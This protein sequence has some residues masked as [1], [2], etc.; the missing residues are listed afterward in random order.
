ME[1]DHHVNIHNSTNKEYNQLQDQPRNQYQEDTKTLMEPEPNTIQNH[2][3]ATKDQTTFSQ[4]NNELQIL[5]Q[6]KIFQDNSL[7]IESD[8][9]TTEISPATKR[10]IS[11]P[12]ILE[13][14]LPPPDT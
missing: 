8:R 7:V 5:N 3:L 9:K 2:A 11:S 14:D 10:Q 6:P 12:E 4:T 13:N 1:T